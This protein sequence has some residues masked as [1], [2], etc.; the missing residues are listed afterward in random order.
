MPYYKK[1]TYTRQ[2]I[3]KAS[4]LP[5]IVPN[6]YQSAFGNEVENGFGNIQLVARAGTGKSTTILWSLRFIPDTKKVLFLA[7]N[8]DIATELNTKIP[9]SFTNV[10][11][12]TLHSLGFAA[13]NY[14]LGKCNIDKMKT[15]HIL[16]DV[17]TIEELGITSSLGF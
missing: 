14:N 11:A 1:K 15:S 17:E 16:H 12:C 10:K 2:N 7:F 13:I 4:S 3:V 9:E 6:S 8:K 5:S